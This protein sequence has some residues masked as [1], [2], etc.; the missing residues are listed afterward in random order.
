MIVIVAAAASPL[1][2]PSIASHAITTALHGMCH[3]DPERSFRDGESAMAL[4][5][6]CTGMYLGLA[7]GAAVAGVRPSQRAP[8]HRIGW[9][10]AVLALG[11]H[12]LLGWIAPAIFD[13][14]ALRV[15]SGLVFGAW[16]GFALFSALAMAPRPRVARA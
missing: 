14:A 16:T 13:H 10:I 5:H 3:Q 7:L 6:R 2:A 9:A 15:S 8:R 1:Y 4:C 11:G 12:V